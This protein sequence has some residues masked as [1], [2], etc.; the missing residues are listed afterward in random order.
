M[1]STTNPGLPGKP[2]NK[3]TYSFA[4]EPKGMEVRQKL[5]DPNDPEKLAGY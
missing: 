3:D 5:R 2:E 1:L 4:A